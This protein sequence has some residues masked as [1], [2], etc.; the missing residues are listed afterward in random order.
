[1]K[2]DLKIF[3]HHIL[4]STEEVENHMRDISEEQFSRDIKT[5]DAVV[6]RI[7]I[8]G[9]V[10]KN[11]PVSF[12]KKYPEVEWREIAG[13]RDKLIHHYFG[14]KMDIV[15]ETSRKD[16]PKLKRQVSKILRSLEKSTGGIALKALKEF[17]SGKTK[18]VRSVDGFADS[19]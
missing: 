5:Q 13:M 11:L 9:E 7:E 12:K 14:I 2:K 6:R 4:E 10:A 3:L 16:L 15:W 19:L 17:R 1:M 18:T 8:I